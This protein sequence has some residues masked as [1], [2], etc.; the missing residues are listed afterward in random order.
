MSLAHRFGREGYRVALIGRR[1][2]RLRGFVSDLAADSIEAAAFTADLIDSAAVPGLIAAIRERFGRIDVVAYGPTA[3]DTGFTSA[4]R[5]TSEALSD[6]LKLF[7]LTPIEV[8][9]AVLPEMIERGDG[10]ILATH[11]ITT[12][13]ALPH[14]S[15]PGTVTAATRNYLHSLNAELSDTGVYVGNLIVGG[16]IA[17]GGK[18]QAAVA[19]GKPSG[20]AAPPKGMALPVFNPDVLAELYWDMN[21]KR[22]RAEEIVPASD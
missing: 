2:E 12:L 14:L 5:L 19:S 11:G 21:S 4:T 16:Y 15:G 13:R 6:R 10:A 18:Y 17:R 9:R 7:L 22:D 8:V 1:E 3:T 20:M